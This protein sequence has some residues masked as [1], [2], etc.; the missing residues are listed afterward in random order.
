MSR[1]LPLPRVHDLRRFNFLITRTINGAAHVGFQLTPNQIAIG[2]PEYRSMR[3][4]LQMEQIHVLPKPAMVAL[5]GFFQPDQMRIQLLFIQPASAVNATQL[6]V[7]LISTPVGT[8]NA[9]QL[10]C[11]RI[12]LSRRCQMRPTA[13]VHPVIARPINRQFFAFRQFS[14]PFRLETF[15]RIL[16]GRDERITRHDFTAQRFIGAD[17]R[18]HL[19]FNRRQII[20]SEWT[21]RSGRHHVIIK[22]VIG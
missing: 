21:A 10:E 7:L 20:H 6:W 22:T 8:G 2:M 4:L 9:R 17:D 5:C 18:A 14:R 16:P 1:L 19:L 12:K 3:F 13:H 11:S 15:A